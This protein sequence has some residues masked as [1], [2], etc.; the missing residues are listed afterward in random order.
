MHILFDTNIFYRNWHPKSAQFDLFFNYIENTRSALLVS[1]LVCEEVDNLRKRELDATIEELNAALKK[2]NKYN[3]S[4]TKFDFDKLREDYSFKSILVS[5]THN[6]EFIHYGNV[7]QEVVVRRALEKVRPFQDEEKGYRDTLIWLSFLSYLKEKNIQGEVIFLSSNS[8]DFYSGKKNGIEFHDD[9]KKDIKEFGLACQITPYD[10]LFN[11]VN[12]RI[13]KDEHEFTSDGIY[14]K[15]LEPL[16]HEV[17]DVAAEYINQLSVSDFRRIALHDHQSSFPFCN[18]LIK[19]R[20][21]IFEGLEDPLVLGYSK[22]SKDLIFL[23][24]QFNLRI[25]ILHF[26]IPTSDYLI[27]KNEIDSRYWEVSSNTEETSFVAYARTYL[28]AGFNFNIPEEKIEGFSLDRVLFVRL[29]KLK[30]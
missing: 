19:F 23:S 28:D 12:A 3:S 29:D 27:N 5:R 9:L 26:S 11:F 16:E 1:D 8:T 21:E 15:Y 20:F 10:T 4:I 7:R 17:Q 14:Q 18:N 24:Y 2:A 22:I 13:N 6:I 25:C 30:N